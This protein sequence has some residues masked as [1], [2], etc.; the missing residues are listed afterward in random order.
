MRTKKPP[1]GGFEFVGADAKRSNNIPRRGT[2]DLPDFKTQQP[3]QVAVFF[4]GA[5]R[6][7]C[8]PFRGRTTCLKNQDSHKGLP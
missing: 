6:V 7:E 4:C 3:H 1:K 8:I 2:H 5:E